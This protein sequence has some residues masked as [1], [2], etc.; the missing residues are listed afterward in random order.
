MRRAVS[1]NS[2]TDRQMVTREAYWLQELSWQLWC[3]VV[4]KRGAR[5]PGPKCSGKEDTFR[6]DREAGFQDECWTGPLQ[7][8]GLAVGLALK[9]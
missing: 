1:Q 9:G 4:G 8:S 2:G 7:A 3:T 5:G 6:T